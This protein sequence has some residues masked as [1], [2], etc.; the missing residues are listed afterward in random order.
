MMHIAFCT[1]KNYLMP[2]GVAMLSVCEQHPDVP[3]TF[4][5]VATVGEKASLEAYD[6]LRQIAEKHGK[7]CLFYTM[8]EEKLSEFVVSALSRVTTTSFSRIFLADLLPTSVEKVLYLDCD[9]L[10]QGPLLGL[11]NT[12]LASQGATIGGA[13]DFSSYSGWLRESLP[14][15]LE[16]FYINTGILLI[17][18]KQWRQEGMTEK[19][20]ACAR[21]H[22][23]PLLDQDVLNVMCC[24]R[25]CRIS[26]TYNMQ[27][28]F[29]LREE[30]F[31]AIDGEGMADVRQHKEQPAILHYTTT[32][33]W[34]NPEL[35]VCLRW[36][37]CYKRSPWA[38]RQL[39]PRPVWF[40][41]SIHYD[42]LRNLYWTDFELVRKTLPIYI[43]TIRLIQKVKRMIKK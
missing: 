16:H 26:S 7:E 15:G 2:T 4:H 42:Y 38:G 40:D 41:Y 1:D 32:K 31:W 33:P 29:L 23:F 3:I 14:L 8:T 24:G 27:V 9:I 21:E 11:W 22:Q 28:E 6:V 20:V 19:C 25:I 30:R 17:D 34:L 43:K 12:D 18:L 10:C 37:E 36:V 35:P 5:V 13:I 39:V